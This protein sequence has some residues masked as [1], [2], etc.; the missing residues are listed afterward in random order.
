ML[1][2]HGNL[3]RDEKVQII[4]LFINGSPSLSHLNLNILCAT[5]GV[6]NA[7][8]DSSEVRSVVRLGF[9]PS[10]LD[11][12]QEKGRAGRNIGASPDNYSYDVFFPSNRS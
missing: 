7:G 9:P 12:S 6:G 2:L 4:D 8:I 3:S 1:R 10:I 11:M 5:S